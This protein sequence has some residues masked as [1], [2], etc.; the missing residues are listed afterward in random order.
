MKSAVIA[1]LLASTS[2]VH[3]RSNSSN[4]LT[5]TGGPNSAA[6]GAAKGETRYVMP[7]HSGLKG[8]DI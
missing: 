4:D 8:F 5:Q 6:P 1:L 7:V 2:A 3:L